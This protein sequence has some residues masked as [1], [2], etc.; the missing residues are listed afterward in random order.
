MDIG[1]VVYSWTGHTL[2]VAVKL[3]EALS[4]S[5]HAVTLERLEVAGNRPSAVGVRPGATDVPLKTRPAIAGYDAL[6]FGAPAWGGTPAS[7]MVSYLEGLTSLEGKK[8]AC[9]ATGVFPAGWG[10]N[11]TLAQMVEICEAKGATV[12][13]SG[14]VGWWSFARGRQI[15]EVIQHLSRLF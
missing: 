7:P 6:V 4:A 12:C 5:G 3:Q 15:A 13:G 1:I 8:V 14:S 9:L 2:S 10:R 11:Q